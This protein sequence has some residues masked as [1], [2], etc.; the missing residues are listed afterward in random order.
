[1]ESRGVVSRRGKVE[2]RAMAMDRL[3]IPDAP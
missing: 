3:T 1:M 2:I